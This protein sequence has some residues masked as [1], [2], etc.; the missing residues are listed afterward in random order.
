MKDL[1]IDRA[2]NPNAALDDQWD[3]DEED[4]TEDDDGD[5]NI[6]DR[7]KFSFVNYRHRAC[8]GSC[9]VSLSIVEGE[10]PWPGQY[11]DVTRARR[12]DNEHINWPRP[13]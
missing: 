10:E 1:T 9:S 11:V 12:T 5:I 13:G 7:S 6:I 4:E 8:G 2:A 3:P